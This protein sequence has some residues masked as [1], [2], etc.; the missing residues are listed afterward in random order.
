MSL[1]PLM[2]EVAAAL[3][4]EYLTADE[5]NQYTLQFD[6][7]IEVQISMLDHGTVLLKAV[8][9]QEPKYD[10]DAQQYLERVLFRSL[11]HLR[12]S[13]DVISLDAET[14]E[15]HLYRSEPLHGLT[16][17]TL[18]EILEQFTNHAEDWTRFLDESARHSNS[19]G[20][21][22]VMMP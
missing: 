9:G 2:S 15:L 16:G 3:Q 20:P 1:E 5:D 11:L 19:P 8:V 10:L 17:I 14:D 12:S 13:N 7:Q 4:V 18:Q 22:H 6:E 21:L